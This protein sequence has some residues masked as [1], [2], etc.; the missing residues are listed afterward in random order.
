MHR[1]EIVIPQKGVKAMGG[2]S[3][4][5]SKV[6]SLGG[7]ANGGAVGASISGCMAGQRATSRLGADMRALSVQVAVTDIAKATNKYNAIQSKVN[8]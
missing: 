4:A 2:T 3:S 8:A 5:M 1:G 7:F 6:A